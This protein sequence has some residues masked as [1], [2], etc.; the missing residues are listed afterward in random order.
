[1]ADKSTVLIVDDEPVVRDVIE[2]LLFKEGYHLAFASNGR[3]ALAYVETTTPDVILLD[4]MMPEMNGFEVCQHLKAD[5]RW[6]HVPIILI[7]A[8]SD[9]KDLVRGLEA[10]ADDFL[11]KPVNEQE[12]RARV[13]SLLRIKKQYDELQAT[14]RLREDLASMIVHDMRLPLTTIIGYSELLLLQGKIPAKYL[15]FLKRI[16]TRA[17]SLNSFLNDMLMVAKM[18]A[19]QMILNRA[20]VDIGQL[21]QELEKSYS[22]IAGSRA[23]KLV[24]DLPTE[25]Q[26][27][28]LDQNL[29]QR[30]LD[31]LISNAIKYS[32]DESTVTVQVEYL[33]VND[34]TQSPSPRLR[35]KVLDEGPGIT[36]EDRERIFEKFETTAL[37]RTST[38]QVGLGLAFCKMAVETHGGR[39]F[40]EANEP[41]GSV[42]TIEI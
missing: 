8:L 1:V 38:V 2:G 19:D 14:L 10:G 11:H 5:K 30:V 42:F 7:T 15:E 29:F 33:A 24:L 26:Q 23:I 17:H 20:P 28:S 3:E 35:L 13:R 27:I 34:E 16:S 40:V 22:F 21:V 36:K 18:E 4:V 25:S 32:P 31:N 9:K 39:I 6:Q 12:L 41:G 37:T